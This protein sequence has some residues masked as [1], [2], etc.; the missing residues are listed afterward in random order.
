[1]VGETQPLLLK[2]KSLSDSRLI[3][4]VKLRNLGKDRIAL[5][6]TRKILEETSPGV[7]KCLF[8]GMANLIISPEMAGIENAEEVASPYFAA[9]ILKRENKHLYSTPRDFLE[10]KHYL[11][12]FSYNIS[13]FRI[14]ACELRKVGCFDSGPGKQKERL[15]FLRKSTGK[16]FV[17]GFRVLYRCSDKESPYFDFY[18]K[19]DE[20]IYI[21]IIYNKFK[22]L[23]EKAK[24]LII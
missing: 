22:S 9:G 24:K 4:E 13:E 11:N 1:M 14:L 19:E 8:Y 20:E 16:N 10:L 3:A 17:A 6:L 7:L 5:G 2:S 21:N 12:D 23:G 15:K 18:D